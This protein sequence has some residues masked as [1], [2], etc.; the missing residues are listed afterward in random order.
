MPTARQ[1]LLAISESVTVVTIS[2]PAT[3]R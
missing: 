1:G 3:D 2:G